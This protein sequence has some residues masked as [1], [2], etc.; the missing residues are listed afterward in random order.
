MD[1]DGHS[2]SLGL[3][4]DLAVLLEVER[5]QTGL[6]RNQDG[7]LGPLMVLDVVLSRRGS[8]ADLLGRG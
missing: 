7:L 4:P 6:Q 3:L 2:A 1:L 8:W 5:H